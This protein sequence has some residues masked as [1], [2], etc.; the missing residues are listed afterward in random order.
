MVHEPSSSEIHKKLQSNRQLMQKSPDSFSYRSQEEE[1]E[2][3]EPKQYE[4]GLRG[5]IKRV[6][7]MFHSEITLVV[8]SNEKVSNLQPFPNQSVNR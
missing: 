5:S 3:E 7:L 1:E 8:D 6:T 4:G 2:E